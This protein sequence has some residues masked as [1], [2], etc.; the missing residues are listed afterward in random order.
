MWA[1]SIQATPSEVVGNDDVGD[2]IKHH[3]DVSCV[4]GA[5]HMTVDFFIGRAILALELC[6][7]ISC[8]ILIGVGSCREEQEQC[9][10]HFTSNSTLFY[11]YYHMLI[12]LGNFQIKYSFSDYQNQLFIFLI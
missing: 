3:L 12:I 4:C 6:L 11:K 5:G 9:R 2:G 7:D 8:C 1:R 10:I